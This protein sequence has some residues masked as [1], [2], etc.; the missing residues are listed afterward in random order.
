M[1]IYPVGFEVR[2]TE[3]NVI[4]VKQEVASVSAYCNQYCIIITLPDF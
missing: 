1:Q 3:E 2:L 4:H